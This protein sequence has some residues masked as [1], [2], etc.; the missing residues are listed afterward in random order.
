MHKWRESSK[1]KIIHKYSKGSRITNLFSGSSDIGLNRVDYSNPNAN[2][3]TDVFKWLEYLSNGYKNYYKQ[4]VIIDAPYNKKF[5]DKYQML[6][7]TPKQFII[8]ANAIDTTKLFNLI[9]EKINPN[10]IILK[11]WN[12]YIPKGYKL[13]KGFLC[14]AGGFRKPT[15]LLILERRMI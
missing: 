14:Y 2:C 15:I 3:N 5:A 10:I 7:N 4:T 9:S 11:S 1:I 8:F 12:Y 6:G 13:K